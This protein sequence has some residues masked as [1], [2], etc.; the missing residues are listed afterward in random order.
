MEQCCVLLSLNC[1]LLVSMQNIKII[2]NC[3][4]VFCLFGTCQN[5]MYSSIRLQYICCTYISVWWF[6]NCVKTI[7]PFHAFRYFEMKRNL[8]VCGILEDHPYLFLITQ[9]E[10]F[11]H[12]LL[13]LFM[14]WDF[15]FIFRVSCFL[16]ISLKIFFAFGLFDAW[17]MGI[18]T[19][20]PKWK[21][22]IRAS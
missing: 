5:E 15:F 10:V 11:Q 14:L 4:V 20:P 9:M 6:W 21:L 12:L 8:F 13:F 22:C 16:R 18:H 3:K 7:G 19:V 2:K 1:S 17:T